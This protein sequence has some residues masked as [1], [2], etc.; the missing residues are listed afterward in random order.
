MTERARWYAYALFARRPWSARSFAMSFDADDHGQQ[1][2]TVQLT[3]D[4][5]DE[6]HERGDLDAWASWVLHSSDTDYVPER[7]A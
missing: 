3:A 1:R 7:G 5:I 6:I 4:S 2:L